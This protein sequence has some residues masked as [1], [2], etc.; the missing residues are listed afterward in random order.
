[1]ATN[2]L[3]NFYFWSE[4]MHIEQT[5]D[6]NDFHRFR[7]CV[8]VCVKWCKEKE[9]KV[10]EIKKNQTQTAREKKKSIWLVVVLEGFSGSIDAIKIAV[11]PNCIVVDKSG[12]TLFIPFEPLFSEFEF[13]VFFSHSVLL[14]FFPSSSLFFPFSYGPRHFI[15][16]L[17]SLFLLFPITRSPR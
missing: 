4:L 5:V 11:R 14:S 16:A 9:I 3:N 1:M 15:L 10:N 2:F 7:R 8:C 17:C 13:A 6:Q 12:D